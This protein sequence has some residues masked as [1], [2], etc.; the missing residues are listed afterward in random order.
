MKRIGFGGLALALVTSA[1]AADWPIFRGNRGLT[2]VAPGKL[3]DQ[4][5][6]LWKFKTAKFSKASAVIANGHAYLGADNG[7]FY[8]INLKTGKQAWVFNTEAPI[9][10]PALVLDG[11]VYFGG[12]DGFAY[13]LDAKTGEQAWKFETGDQIVGGPNWMKSPDGKKNTC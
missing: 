8:A 7:N 3:P 6:L 4:L 9:E 5:A 11:R 2:G 1:M 10:A 12:A 13:A